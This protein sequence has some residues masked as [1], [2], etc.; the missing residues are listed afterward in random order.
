MNLCAEFHALCNSRPTHSF[1]FDESKIPVNGIYVLF[2][3]GETAHDSNRIVRVGGHRGQD[4][5]WPRL[6]EHF[7]TENKD[8]SV[9]RQH[10]GR[11][12][13]TRDND[14]FL[15]HWNIDLTPAENRQRY[16]G[17]IDMKKQAT[18]EKAV[19]QYIQSHFSL[20]VFR[21][22]DKQERAELEKRMIGTV[23]QCPACHASQGWLGRHHPNHNISSSGLWNI[24]QLK[25]SGLTAD[26]LV[27]LKRIVGQ[28]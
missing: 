21:V 24:Q 1:P 9:F 14:P 15:E 18:I 8:R 28:S 11:A 17:V 7:L 20:V 25:H 26:D 13:L 2:E 27:Q 6:I 12:I 23:A 3:S 16:A 19:T 10:I 22:Q 5:L 4:R